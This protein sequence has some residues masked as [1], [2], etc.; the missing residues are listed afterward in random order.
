MRLEQFQQ[1]V[2]IEKHQSISKAAKALFM[3]QSSLSGSLHSLEKEIGVRLF[4]RTTAGVVPT[5]EGQDII[6]LARQALDCASQMLNYGER[7]KELRGEVKL[8]ITQSF[9]YLFS[10]IMVAFKRR[11]P[12]AELRLEIETPRRIVEALEQGQANLGLSMWGFLPE[13]TLNVFGQAALRYEAFKSHQMMLFV[14]QDSALANNEEVGMEEMQQEQFLSYSS[15]YWTGV[16]RHIQMDTEALVMNDREALKRMISAGEGVAI[17]PESF[18]K[19]DIYCE[20]GMIRL[21]PI[22]GSENFGEAI[23]Y[24]LYPRKRQLTLL[25]QK[26]LELL[27]E[28]LKEN[29]P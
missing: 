20:Q 14:S 6:Q 9:G 7:H 3:A 16:N 12:K 10:D 23:E 27:R 25:E 1:I 2:E 11:F 8:M 18:A 22:K 17:L 13:H 28:L 4:E 21:I 29:Q 26:T 19:R 15:V 24:L 5:P